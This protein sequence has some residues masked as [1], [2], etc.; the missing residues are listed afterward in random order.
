MQARSHCNL[1]TLRTAHRTA[2]L[3]KEAR[4]W[5]MMVV[6]RLL[7]K[8]DDDA[9]QL[10]QFPTQHKHLHTVRQGKC[11]CDVQSVQRGQWAEHVTCEAGYSRVASAAT[12]SCCELVL[13][14]TSHNKYR[15]HRKY[16]L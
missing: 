7:Q 9:Q 1:P 15:N 6:A 11:A 3:L 4:V 10:V 12:M 5:V 16:M 2:H 14:L 8:A 13:F